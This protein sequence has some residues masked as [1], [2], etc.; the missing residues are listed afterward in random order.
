MTITT[1][2]MQRRDVCAH[3]C[4]SLLAVF[5][6]VVASTNLY[7]GGLIS[8]LP[9]D[10][11]FVEFSLQFRGAGRLASVKRDGLLWL[12]SV[13]QTDVQGTKH[14]WLALK[15]SRTEDG[16]QTEVMAKILVPESHD[17]RA[18]PILKQIQRGWIRDDKGKVQEITPD[19]NLDRDVD[20]G[21]LFYFLNAPTTTTKLPP[22]R[23]E[24]ALG[25]LSCEGETGTFVVEDYRNG[26]EVKMS[27][28]R[29]QDVPFGTASASFSFT[30]SGNEQSSSGGTFEFNVKRI[31]QQAKSEFSEDN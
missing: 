12:G 15:L 27:V 21:P 8:E 31:G 20:L 3:R 9:T 30:L 6:V 2:D 14:R 18:R 16:E 7:A 19:T 1:K 24:T 4:F 23:I 10:G 17:F 26:V 13:G 25:P 11:K 22:V 5:C 28:R 29:H